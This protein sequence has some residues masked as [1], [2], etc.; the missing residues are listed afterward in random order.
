MYVQAKQ[1]PAVLKT[2]LIQPETWI[3]FI[4]SCVLLNYIHFEMMFHFHHSFP[5]IGKLLGS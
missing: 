3:N 4:V 1:E 5:Y 2:G